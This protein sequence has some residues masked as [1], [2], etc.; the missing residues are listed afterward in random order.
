VVVVAAA[1]PAFAASPA[2]P[3]L[4]ITATPLGSGGNSNKLKLTFS[5]GTGTLIIGPVQLNGTAITV[6]PTAG[7]AAN[8]G[9]ASGNGQSYEA[10]GLYT[11]TY[12]YQSQTYTVSVVGT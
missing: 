4:T 8:G 3:P 5:G 9:I 1:A 2:V 12:T 6:T 11:V 7:V 10:G